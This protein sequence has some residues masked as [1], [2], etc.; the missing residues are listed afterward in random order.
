MRRISYIY[1]VAQQFLSPTGELG[2]P[3]W[4]RAL[5]KNCKAVDPEDAV[6]EIYG[7]VLRILRKKVAS[8]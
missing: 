3:G 5:L 2:K 8:G 6:R 7:E 4:N 1:G